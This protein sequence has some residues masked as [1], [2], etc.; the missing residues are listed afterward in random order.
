MHFDLADLRLIVR[1]AEA[2]SLTR[3]AEASF[4]SLPAASTRIKNLEES[5]GAKLLYRTS[6]GVT[7]TP[8]GQ[9]FVHHAR[10]VLAQLEQLAGD[11]QEYAKGIKGH[12]RIASTTTALSEFLPPVLRSFLQ[13]HPD[14]DIDLHERPSLEIVRAVSESQTD[15]GIVAGPVRT[16]ALEVIPY[17]TDNLVLVVANGHELANETRVPFSRTLDYN[18]VGLQKSSAIHVFLRQ[19][20]AAANR[21]LRMRIEVSNFE[22]V[23]RMVEADIGVGIVPLSSA[24]RHAERLGVKII[25]LED[26][27]ALRQQ[28]VLVRQLEALP[29]FGKDLV[30][31]LREDARRG[32]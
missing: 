10:T 21:S 14:V 11:M 20:S 28:H 27:W 26:E 5:V 30:N 1:V 18:H 24:K 2:N 16:E 25:G 23:C 13:A 4:L 12:L 3:A 29:S 9:A 8:P 17:R 15:I 32:Y 7:L 6:Q 19:V 31:L 22:T